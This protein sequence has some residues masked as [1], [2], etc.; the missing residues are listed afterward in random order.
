MHPHSKHRTAA[1]PM[2][3]EPIG[4]ADGMVVGR[5]WAG[6]RNYGWVE[7]AVPAHLKPKSKRHLY[8]N[9]LLSAMIDAWR[10]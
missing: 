9:R 2:R 6:M 10:C 3:H 7:L 5:L 8:E 4:L 1:G